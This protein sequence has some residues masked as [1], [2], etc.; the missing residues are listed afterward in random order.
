M[1]KILHLEHVEDYLFTGNF[2]Q[3]CD[4]LGSM[5]DKLSGKKQPHTIISGK[6][7]G[8]PAIVFGIHP[9]NGKFFVGTKS[10]FNKR[11]PKICYGEEDIIAFYG[12]KRELCGK[13]ITVFNELSYEYFGFGTLP[14]GV[15]QG[16]LMFTRESKHV[17]D[18]TVF[19]TPNTITYRVNKKSTLGEHILGAT[20]GIVVHTEYVGPILSEVRSRPADHSGFRNSEA[21]LF[22][23]PMISVN[24]P[25]MSRLQYDTIVDSLIFCESTNQAIVDKTIYVRH[26]EM[27]KKFVNYCVRI[28]EIHP[29]V[30]MYDT[31]LRNR[32]MKELCRDVQDKR[33][34]FVAIFSV[35]RHLIYCKSLILKVL[36]VQSAFFTEVNG[37]P[38]SGEGLV[39]TYHGV[40][41]K[42]VDRVEFSRHNFA[43]NR[44][45]KA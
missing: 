30:E 37:K 7:D 26:H 44:F 24:E 15:F 36:N 38:M 1:S 6:Y 19:F 8:A 31:F 9:E 22:I 14:T 12:D 3:A 28:G 35:H 39:V 21:V 33:P 13:L 25:M 27:L 42:M 41:C 2:N 18:R 45:T 43:N 32:E 34:Q 10:V 5:C 16:D 17:D 20:M 40:P 23:D 29:E 11:I 4:V